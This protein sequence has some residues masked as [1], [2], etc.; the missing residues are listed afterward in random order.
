MSNPRFTRKN[1]QL[2]SDSDI[3]EP[4]FFPTI[5][6]PLAKVVIRKSLTPTTTP[7]QTIIDSVI[8]RQL[9]YM[10]Y[11]SH[12]NTDW[13]TQAYIGSTLR[14][15]CNVKIDNIGL[16]PLPLPLPLATPLLL[17]TLTDQLLFLHNELLFQQELEQRQVP[18]EVLCS[19][20]PYYHPEKM[21]NS[22][23]SSS[24]FKRDIKHKIKTP[25][26]ILQ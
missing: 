12:T 8:N 4:T 2:T 16:L 11:H 10:Y 26:K 9:V 5:T 22:L 1:R 14:Q 20:G 19:P 17:I 13:H 24:A 23:N 3:A 18:L 6:V 25:W 15:Y 7:T 21:E